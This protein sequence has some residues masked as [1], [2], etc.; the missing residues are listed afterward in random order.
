MHVK[1]RS[2]M[3]KFMELFTG[4]IVVNNKLTINDLE[5]FSLLAFTTNLHF[6][7]P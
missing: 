3:G 1:T 7:K 2:L 6:H 4:G 5:L